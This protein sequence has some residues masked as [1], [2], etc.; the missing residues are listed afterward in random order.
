[1]S[2]F[3]KREESQALEIMPLEAS[4]TQDATHTAIPSNGVGRPSRVLKLTPKAS[5]LA[6]ANPSRLR[7][8]HAAIP[9]RS[10][11]QAVQA[12]AEPTGTLSRGLS[13]SPKVK[14]AL[15]HHNGRGYIN[16]QR[17]IRRSSNRALEVAA[18]LSA[19]QQPDRPVQRISG[20]E[21]TFL[22]FTRDANGIMKA[23][24]SKKIMLTLHMQRNVII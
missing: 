20:R 8:S 5:L 4:P 9:R 15:H 7:A 21:A 10:P 17:R 16:G 14:K 13:T 6:E 22:H 24:S 23:R 19:I 11:P 12:I 1:M 2:Q 3:T 18:A